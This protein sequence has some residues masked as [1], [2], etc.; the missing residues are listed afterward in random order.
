MGWPLII[1]LKE[2]YMTTKKKMMEVINKTD[3]FKSKVEI[4]KALINGK[5]VKNIGW[6]DDQYLEMV[7]DTLVNEEG[8]QI[9]EEFKTPEEWVLNT[10]KVVNIV[11]YVWYWT[12]YPKYAH[13][14]GTYKEYIAAVHCFDDVKRAALLSNTL[15]PQYVLVSKKIVDTI[16]HE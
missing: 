13:S 11:Q 2:I 15:G 10:R 7:N 4:Y 3:P 14:P 1:K 9:V 8:K 12:E 5:H 6:S 16:I